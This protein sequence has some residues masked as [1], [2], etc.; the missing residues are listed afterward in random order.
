MCPSAVCRAWIAGRRMR[1]SSHCTISKA[2]LGSL[3]T[4]GLL[5]FPL[6]GLRGGNLKIPK[7]TGKLSRGVYLASACS[8]LPEVE[9]ERPGGQVGFHPARIVKTNKPGIPHPPPHALPCNSTTNIP[10]KS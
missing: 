5:L 9:V 4:L 2:S 10:Y 8:F 1:R 3:H 7:N 6:S